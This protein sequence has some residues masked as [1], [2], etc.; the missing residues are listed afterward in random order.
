M[1]PSQAVGWSM[2]QTT[3]IT[4]LVS[5]RIYHGIRPTGTTVPCINYFEMG[6]GQR[7]YGFERVT[8]TINC[9]AATPGAALA[10]ARQVTDLFHGSYSGGTY[11]SQ[12]GFEISRA[13]LNQSQGVIPE[14]TDNIF[15]APVDI[16]LVYP[17]TSVT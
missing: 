7:A 13:S 9:R 14:P 4:A 16:L 10:V 1:T 15:N 17:T 3:A 5:T 11:G 6:G 12:N 2:A 8:Y